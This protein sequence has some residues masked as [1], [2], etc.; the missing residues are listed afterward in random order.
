MAEREP[1]PVRKVIQIAVADQ[2]FT[3]A[4]CD[5]GSI[6]QFDSEFAIGWHRLP[7]I[8]QEAGAKQ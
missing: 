3:H 7:D 2:R 1:P 5:G 4:L 6:W 8:P